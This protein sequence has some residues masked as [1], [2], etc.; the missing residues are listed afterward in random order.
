MKI[1]FMGIRGIPACYSGFE[2]FVE[3]FA[4]DLAKNGYFVAVY[5][6]VYINFRDKKYKGVRIIRLPTI[7]KKH[8][9]TIFHTFISVIHSLFCRYDIVYFCGVGNSPLVFIPRLVGSKVIINVDGLDWRREKWSS[10]AR[11]YLRICELWAIVFATVLITDSRFV[12]KYYRSIY[13]KETTYIPYG[14]EMETRKTVTDG[15]IFK[16]LGLE[17][18]KYILFVSRLVPENGA[19][20]LIEAYNKLHTSLKLVIVGDAPYC[21]RYIAFLKSAESRNIIF[22]GFVFGETYKQLM[23]NAYIF[24]LPSVVSGTRVVLLEAMASGNCVVAGDGESNLEVMDDSGYSYD[25]RGGANALSSSLRYLIDNP[26]IVISYR[27]KAVE[28]I[29]KFYSYDKMT[30]EYDNLF[31]VWR[32]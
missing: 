32:K 11:L 8:L 30:R 15:Y 25:R 14:V 12:H 6:R 20:I 18:E 1:A 5:N 19:H 9:E 17:R 2:T 29:N 21:E 3:A 26:D 4:V 23:S 27:I 28:R 24:V 13:G 7:R 16:K 22:P 10:P 31:S